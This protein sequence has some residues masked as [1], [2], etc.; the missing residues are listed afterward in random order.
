VICAAA[1]I[2]IDPNFDK[3][4]FRLASALGVTT[5]VERK[6]LLDGKKV[7]TL[8]NQQLEE[9]LHKSDYLQ[10][11][12]KR[13]AKK[14]QRRKKKGTGYI[15]EHGGFGR[16]GCATCMAVARD[17]FTAVSAG[18]FG[19]EED[20]SWK[21]GDRIG[22]R[23]WTNE[24]QKE[25]G[26]VDD[27]VKLYDRASC[28]ISMCICFLDSAE[29][30]ADLD[31]N[32][33]YF[34][35]EFWSCIFQCGNWTRAFYLG[36]LYAHK[37]AENEEDTNTDDDDG[38]GSSSEFDSD[39]DYANPYVFGGPFGSYSDDDDDSDEELGSSGVF[40]YAEEMELLSQG[41][42][43]WEIEDGLRALE[44]LHSYY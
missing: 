19:L 5:M 36:I 41:I 29:S 15:C 33:A 24:Q 10:K 17:R 9:L 11:Q 16:Y 35:N 37:D 30:L 39:E 44:V 38:D 21:E 3:S 23:W 32:T 6:I 34:L 8:P 1:A 20:S 26:V 18:R 42:K 4:Y 27:C 40:T 28:M 14:K 2:V 43:P 12:A 13:K 31:D 7:S 25:D 22:V